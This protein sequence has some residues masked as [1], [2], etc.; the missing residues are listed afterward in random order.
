MRLPSPVWVRIPP[1]ALARGFCTLA[2]VLL[3][4][5]AF[6]RVWDL[7][8]QGQR[9]WEGSEGREPGAQMMPCLFLSQKSFTL[10]QSDFMPKDL[11]QLTKMH[12]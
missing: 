3:V 12:T 6:P 10:L 7:G 11:G 2:A 4:P 1:L 8:R 5:A 9:G